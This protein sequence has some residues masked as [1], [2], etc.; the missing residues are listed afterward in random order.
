MLAF[1]LVFAPHEH[2]FTVTRHFDNWMR[3]LGELKARPTYDLV[4]SGHG[5]PTDRSALD[6]MI[7]Y[8][9]AG[10]AAHAVS[11]EANDYASRMKAAFP[12]RRHPGWI[13]IAS[14]LYSGVDAYDTA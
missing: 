10:K 8:L 9:Q 12:Q 1:D 14:L 6:A 7:T 5:E 11:K 13:D 4:I 2:V 3:I